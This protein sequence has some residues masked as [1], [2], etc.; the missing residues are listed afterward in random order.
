M[1]IV[2]LL[3]I[4]LLSAMLLAVSSSTYADGITSNNVTTNTT[5]A[6]T[7]DVFEGSTITVTDK[8]SGIFP[9]DLQILNPQ[10]FGTKDNYEKTFSLEPKNGKNCNV[11]VQNTGTV[12]LSVKIYRNGT[13]Q[14]DMSI[15]PGT[16][17]TAE[18]YNAVTADYRVNV[19]NSVG[20]INDFNIAIRQF[21]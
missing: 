4:G 18:I 12:T 17:K 14:A 3:G 19:N 6:T 16:Q 8:G 2:K 7:N 9:F 13:L 21:E 5:S 15:A 10:H 1:K 20:G 11:W